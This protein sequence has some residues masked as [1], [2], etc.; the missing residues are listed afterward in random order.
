MLVGANALLSLLF[1]LIWVDAPRFGYGDEPMAGLAILGLLP[2]W[3]MLITTAV[4]CGVIGV[5]PD[6]TRTIRSVMLMS[7]VAGATVAVLWAFEPC[8]TWLSMR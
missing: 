5:V 1:A 8:P 3:F 6:M 4:G 7:A 2:V